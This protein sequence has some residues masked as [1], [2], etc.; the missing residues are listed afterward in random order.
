MNEFTLSVGEKRGCLE[1]IDD[2]SEYQQLIDAKISCIEE[3]KTEFI[4]A[5]EEG[6]LQHQDWYGWN[7]DKT[8]IT[9]AF[10]Y[11]PRSFKKNYP[12]S[13]RVAD[14]DEAIAALKA[15]RTIEHYKCRC[16]KCGK[17]RY[18]AF[19]TL[20]TNP[21]YCFKP[22]YFSS[23]FTYSTKA[24]NASF[25]KRQKYENDES[26][27]LVD[28]KSKIVPSEEYCDKW[29]DKR[30]EELRKQAEKDSSII[31]SL[32]RVH[33]N[34]YDKNYVGLNYESLEIL[35]C[36]TESLESVPIPHFNQRHQKIY[37]KVTVYK[38]YRCRCFL[39]GK[40]QNITCDK[41]GIYPPTP[42]GYRAYN[43]YWSAV[44]C[45]C[46]PISS[47]QWIVNKLLFE[48]NIHYQVE[49]SFPDLYGTFGKKR[50]RFDFAVFDD[51]HSLKCLIE[52]Q[53]EQHYGPVDEFGGEYQYD[54]QVQND[55]LKRKYAKAHNIPL[56]EIS[57]KNKS[58]DSIKAVLEENSILFYS[59]L[60]P[61]K[62]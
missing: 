50:L 38:Q 6:K 26:V 11:E 13:I 9:P 23:K 34:N 48:N 41:F 30:T 31:A 55:T 53:G 59:R 12:G 40:E 54:A 28:D 5:I 46:H 20:Q 21:Q 15:K 33:A 27:C 18:Y 25:R 56:I 24:A 32:P 14:F 8:V 42:Y 52:C 3:E 60:T 44:F 39:C 43:G 16:R 45:D 61:P 17:I 58:F 36:L 37:G 49:Y 29:N 35:E 4:N 51:N 7:G 2:G 1:I 57:Y 10:V 47:F 19:E 22:I 62:P